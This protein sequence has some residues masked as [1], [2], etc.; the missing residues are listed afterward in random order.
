[1]MFRRCAGGSFRRVLRDALGAVAKH[2]CKPPP[3]VQDLRGTFDSGD[4][5][6]ELACPSRQVIS[7]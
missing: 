1:M 3:S 6:A 4:I 2:G 7:P 5:M